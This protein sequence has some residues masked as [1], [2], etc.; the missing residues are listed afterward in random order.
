MNDYDATV[1]SYRTIGMI[2]PSRPPLS[3][4]RP[5]A[6]AGDGQGLFRGILCASCLNNR[7]PVS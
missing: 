3:Q 4:V 2:L 7:S 6:W 1:L 5:P